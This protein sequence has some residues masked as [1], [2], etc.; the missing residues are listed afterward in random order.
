MTADDHRSWRRWPGLLAVVV[1]WRIEVTAV[2]AIGLL[3]HLAGGFFVGTLAVTTAILT[4]TVP[5]I[6]QAA[7]RSWQLVTLPHRVRTALAQAGAVDRDGRLPWVLWA[8]SAG[9]NVVMVE[10]KLRPG[11]TFDDLSLARP[12]IAVACAAAEVVVLVRRCR[13]D[14]AVVCLVRPR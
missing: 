10:V 9:P 14:R 8:R 13:P 4:A 5:A 7:V 2:T 1:R 12:H 6:R 3:W 11:V